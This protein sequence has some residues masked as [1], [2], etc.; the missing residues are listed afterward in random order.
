MSRIISQF[1]LIFLLATSLLAQTHKQRVTEAGQMIPAPERV[2]EIQS[3]LSSHGYDPGTTWE[4]TQE[5]C[6]KIAD[7]HGWQTDHAPDARVLILIGLGGPHSDPAVAQLQGDRL[8]QDQ[9]SEAARPKST[10]TQSAALSA[11]S[12]PRGVIASAPASVSKPVPNQL[13]S[14]K[15]KSV[16]AKAKRISPASVKPKGT[17]TA[18]LSRKTA[19]Y[20][21][22][23]NSKKHK[24]RKLA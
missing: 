22:A 8:D 23:A 16:V 1:C 10:V 5:V 2:A 14:Q 17:A 4:E 15:N 13:V 18:K 21:T 6:R 3:A 9:R 24:R 11:Q 20:K 7:E 19:S 12:S